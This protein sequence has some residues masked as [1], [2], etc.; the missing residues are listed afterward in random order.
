MRKT[1]AA[2]ALALGILITSFGAQAGVVAE[3]IGVRG[4]AWSTLRE[5]RTRLALG[6]SV[7]EGATVRTQEGGRVKLRFIDG[8]VVV[9]SDASN[10]VVEKFVLDSDGR[11]SAGN[12]RLDIGLISQTVTTGKSES[13]R[14]TTPTIVT[15]VRGTQ[16]L[17]EV[18][19]D[20]ATEVSIRS[21]AVAVT[22][23]DNSMGIPAR[24]TRNFPS[25]SDINPPVLL[26]QANFGTVCNAEG[27]CN[28]ATVWQEERF[29]QLEDRCSGV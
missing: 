25:R 13:W 15:A 6:A 18:K 5:V 22:A 20:K 17:I 27:Q 16:Y 10:F 2:I 23:R 4:E 14:V 29:R 19:S 11:R 12:M 8:S 3:V 7:E 24:K 26:D 28:T 9:V 1:C 21:G